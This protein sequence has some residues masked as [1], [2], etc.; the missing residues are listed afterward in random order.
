MEQKKKI[1]I[2]IIVLAVLLGLSLVALGY[3]LVRNK[4]ANNDPS[5]VTVPE[6]CR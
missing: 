1:K 6:S 2:V 4:P 5:T 3:T